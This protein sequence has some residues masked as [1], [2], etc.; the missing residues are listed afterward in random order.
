MQHVFEA[1][2]RVTAFARCQRDA[3]AGVQFGKGFLVFNQ[4]RLFHKQNTVRLQLLEQS[5]RHR[6]VGTPVEVD[7]DTEVVS[8]RFADS[9]QLQ[10]EAVDR[11]IIG[12]PTHRV[13][14]EHLNGAKAEVLLFQRTARGFFGRVG[15]DPAVDF[16]FVANA[17]AEELVNRNAQRLGFDVPERLIDAGERAG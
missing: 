14:T 9:L 13:H 16:H 12:N 10:A 7:G 2:A 1:P 11:L 8:D 6:F 5:L 15:V 3:R 17:S 4:H